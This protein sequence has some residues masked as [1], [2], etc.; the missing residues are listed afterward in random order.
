MLS[1]KVT[2]NLL[3]KK[4]KRDTVYKEGVRRGKKKRQRTGTRNAVRDCQPMVGKM[5]ASLSPFLSL[6]VSPPPSEKEDGGVIVYSLEGEKEP[7]NLITDWV[8][9]IKGHG[10]SL[11]LL[12]VGCIQGNARRVCVVPILLLLVVGKMQ[13]L[14]RVFEH[15]GL[16]SCASSSPPHTTRRYEIS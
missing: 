4:C 5:K 13:P 16:N 11:L 1:C 10:C 7:K 9:K 2:Q 8:I 6:A 14:R 3:L 12:R 15:G